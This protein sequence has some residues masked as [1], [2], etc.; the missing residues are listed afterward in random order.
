MKKNIAFGQIYGSKILFV[1][2]IG[3]ITKK[4][5]SKIKKYFQN[6]LFVE[7]SKKW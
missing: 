5:I 6:A 2:F 4:K 1:A 7:I 3:A